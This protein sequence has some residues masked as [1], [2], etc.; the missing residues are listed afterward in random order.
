MTLPIG[1]DPRTPQPLRLLVAYDGTNFAGFQMQPDQRT[2]QG[3][4]SDALERIAQRPVRT[5]GAGRTDAGVHALGQVVSIDD[6]DG[7]DPDVVLRAMPSLL[8]P[9]LAVVDAQ[10]GPQRFEARA[11]A[12]WRSYAYLLWCSPAPNP[13]YA[14][15][16]VWIP[17]RIDVLLLNAA[18][19]V[20]VGTHDFTSFGRVRLEQTPQR[21]IIEATAVQDGPFIRVRITGESFLHQ[22]VRSIVGTAL[23]VALGRKPVSWM[24]EALHARD[25]AAAGQVAPPHGLALTDVGYRNA[26]WPRRQPNAWPWSDRVVPHAERGSA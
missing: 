12:Q 26:A 5:R 19:K 7:L 9:D 22:M 1:G 17:D 24:R 8:S 20:V 21:R 13:L 23:E 15:Y 16:A 10:L 11:S 2:V 6:A 3:A 4:L 25:R 14:R 18:L